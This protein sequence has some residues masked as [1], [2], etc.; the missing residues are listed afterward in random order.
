[1]ADSNSLIKTDGT[2]DYTT[3]TS[4]FTAK[5]GETGDHIARLANENHTTTFIA[6]NGSTAGDSFTIQP[7]SGAEHDGRHRNI[8]G[9]GA[10]VSG[11]SSD[12][13]RL[14]QTNNKNWLIKDICLTQT[15][16]NKNCISIEDNG[17]F[18]DVERCIFDGENNAS[19][20]LSCKQ[21]AT[22]NTY[23]SIMHRISRG[24][25]YRAGGSSAGEVVG[26]TII[27][28]T[29]AAYGMLITSAATR[30]ANNII[31]NF[32]TE[33]FFG[34]DTSQTNNVSN[35]SS[36][37]TAVPEYNGGG[38]GS[39]S[40]QVLETGDTPTADYVAFVNLTNGSNDLHIVDLAHG[41]Y[42][43]LALDGGVA[44]LG[45]GFDIDRVARRA[46]TPEIG[47]D[48]ISGGGG[49]T[50]V[51]MTIGESIAAADQSTGKLSAVLSVSESA[52]ANDIDQGQYATSQE[53][54]EAVQANDLTTALF[55]ALLTQNLG[56]IASDSVS[57]KAKFGLTLNESAAGTDSDTGK[58]AYLTTLSESLSGS[59]SLSFTTPGI[60]LTIGE[61]VASSDN[62]SISAHFKMTIGEAANLTDSASSKAS[63]ISS[64]AESI[65]GSDAFNRISVFKLTINEAINA[66]D[67]LSVINPDVLG[68]ITASITI[69]PLITASSTINPTITGTITVN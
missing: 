56:A 32:T 11:S 54:I 41:T 34:S 66:L 17:M 8:S 19:F 55:N 37:S 12:T 16:S 52:G 14:F 48:D 3:L 23:D 49:G 38:G 63:L 25:D 44:G 39:N 62:L 65:S 27:G 24:L 68:L 36:D 1:M 31:V 22:V 60:I 6:N 35:L 42:T 15:G 21:T 26:N 30:I 58:A 29:G 18:A 2:G 64:I 67:L 4:W 53:M 20:G 40:V 28:G 43:N 61:T 57:F 13:L 33:C 46:V 50:T 59:D 10:E 7:D 47:A 51:V 45:S 69:D 5:D 9:T